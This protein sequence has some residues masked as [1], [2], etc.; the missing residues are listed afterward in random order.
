MLH[1]ARKAFSPAP[2]PFPVLHID[3][4]RNFPEVLEFRDRTVAT[5]GLRLVVGSV[6]D[7]ID[8]GLIADEVGTRRPGTGCR[9]RLC[10]GP[11]GSTS[12]THSSV[13]P[14]ATRRRHGPRSASTAF[15]TSTGSGIRR[16]S[17]LSFGTFST[18]VT[19]RASTSG[20]SH[21]PTGRARH[22][23]VHRRRRHRCAVHL[24]R[25]PANGLR[26]GRDADGRQRTS[27]TRRGCRR[28]RGQG[29]VPHRRRRRLHR[30]RRVTG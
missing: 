6:Q 15:A 29:P 7:D 19:T 21:C 8:A 22:L 12:S 4:G 5:H 27:R 23:A 30:L 24:L 17:A 16:T 13:V 9:P 2:P 1:V 28:L 18:V 14:D 25:A 10:C 11:F 20:S 26:E 3:T